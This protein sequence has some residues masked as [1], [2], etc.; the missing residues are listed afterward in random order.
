MLALATLFIHLPFYIPSL[1]LPTVR[2]N[3]PFNSTAPAPMRETASAK[4]FINIPIYTS[5]F[6]H[7]FNQD[8]SNASV[9]VGPGTIGLQICEDDVV[10]HEWKISEKAISDD[11]DANV[12]AWSLQCRLSLTSP[13]ALIS[14][15]VFTL[16][17]KSPFI[18][19]S[20]DSDV[21]LECNDLR[22]LKGNG[23]DKDKDYG[24]SFNSISLRN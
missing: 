23:C 16:S 2:N 17:P 18:D 10:E 20:V 12:D 19:G 5:M 11:G 7:F 22:C 15:S 8:D 4:V 1:A 14:H 9:L 24:P 13:I 21:V 3:V 6:S